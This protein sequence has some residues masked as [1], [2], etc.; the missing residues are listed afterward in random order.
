MGSGR[1]KDAEFTLTGLSLI[2]EKVTERLTGQRK[3]YKW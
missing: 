1:S 2:R 3:N